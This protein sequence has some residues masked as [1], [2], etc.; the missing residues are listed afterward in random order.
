VRRFFSLYLAFFK[1]QLK[2]LIEYRLDFALGIIGL[3]FMQLATL[4]MLLAV[5]TQVKAVAGYSFDEVL[6]VFGFTQLVR[7][8]DHVYNDNIWFVAASYVKDGRFSQFL[9]RPLNPLAHVVMERVCVDGLGEV[10]LGAVVFFY[11]KG[12][13]GLVFGLGGWMVFTL[14]LVT[15]LVV[16]FAI[17]LAFASLAF[18]TTTSQEIMTL[19]YETS[20]FTRFPI[21]LYRNRFVQFVITFVLP[22]AL[23]G[24]FPMLYFL[25]DDA[26]IA[27][28]TGLAWMTR[29][30][31]VIGVPLIAAAALAAAYTIWKRGLRN[32]TGTGT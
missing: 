11:A 28:M 29:V 15:A 31:L 2:A 21:E 30:H 19:A 32:Y 22:F 13:L 24:F 27:G 14:F 3:G 7:G 16:Y 9:V 18:W 23:A 20:A 6:L 26:Y 25:R 8:I 5:F 12:S 17:K 10:L 1:Q 4:L